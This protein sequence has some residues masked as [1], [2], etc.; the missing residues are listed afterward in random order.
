MNRP[1]IFILILLSEVVLSSCKPIVMKINNVTK[2]QFVTES[3]TVD[4]LKKKG[5]TDEST[6]FVCKDSA[7]IISLIM[8]VQALPSANFFN[9][10][11]NL[12]YYAE[13]SCTGKA[14]E[15]AESLTKSSLNRVDPSYNFSDVIKSI[16]PEPGNF[17][18]RLADYDYIVVLYWATYLGMLNKHAFEIAAVLNQNH[19][20][21]IKVIYVNVDFQ[22]SW[23]MK[24][25]PE[26]KLN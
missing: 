14:K 17:P 16:K 26:I 22:K 21:K 23:G 24:S 13:T 2:P 19:A 5:I 1:A 25:I 7:S 18:F 8:K 10:N 9:K 15:C 3:Q 12:L 4:F 11:G 6:F 20:L